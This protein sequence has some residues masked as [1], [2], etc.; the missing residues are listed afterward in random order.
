MM[1]RYVGPWD[2]DGYIISGRQE[3][4]SEILAGSSRASQGAELCP[5]SN[6]AARVPLPTEESRP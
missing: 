5:I 6:F 1:P 2:V 3:I 4:N